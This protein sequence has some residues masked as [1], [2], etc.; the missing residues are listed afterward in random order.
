MIIVVLV[1]RIQES[2]TGEKNLSINGRGHFGPTYQNDQTGQSGPP[3]AGQAELK[4][5][6]PLDF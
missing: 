2:G 4:R 6:I 3:Y 5:F 1:S